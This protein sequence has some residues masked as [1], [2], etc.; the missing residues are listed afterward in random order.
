MPEYTIHPAAKE[1]APAK[2]APKPPVAV[3]V[4]E[5]E[6]KEKAVMAKDAS[7]K[8]AKAGK[9]AK[10]SRAKGKAAAAKEPAKKKVKAAEKPAK[11]KTSKGKK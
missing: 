8:P 10:T 1:E 9:A 11:S 4:P 5:A 7:E 6:V 3:E 2:R